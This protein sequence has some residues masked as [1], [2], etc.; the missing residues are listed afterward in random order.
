MSPQV[1]VMNCFQSAGKMIL[2]MKNPLCWRTG[3]HWR[4]VHWMTD[5]HWRMERWMMGLCWRT[6]S[7]KKK[8]LL[9]MNRSWKMMHG[10]MK[11]P[12]CWKQVMMIRLEHMVHFFL[13][14]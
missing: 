2:L 14:E 8:Q 5:Q 11:P 13:L 10:W 9:K 4:M 7:W 3:Q 6:V 12:Y 1:P